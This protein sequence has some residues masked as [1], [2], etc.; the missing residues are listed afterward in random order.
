[1]YAVSTTLSALGP[2]LFVVGFMFL[3]LPVLSNRSTP[4]R[5]AVFATA[6][7]LSWRYA[8]WRLSQTIPDGPLSAGVVMGWGFALLETL[9]IVSSTMSFVILSRRRDRSKETTDNMNWYGAAAPRVDVFIATY[10]E[11]AAL[12]ERTIAGAKAMRYANFKVFVLDDKRRDWLRDLCAQL[13]VGYITRQ[14]NA[15][16]KAGNINNGLKLRAAAAD[17]P[18]FVAVLD[19]DFIPHVGFLSRA[20]ALFADQK[21]GLTQTPQ[22]FF[23]ADP[24]Q[25]N[26]AIAAGYPDEQRYFF[27]EAQASRDAWGMTICCGTSSVMRVAAVEAIGGMP[28]ESVTED[29]L[30]S[31]RLAA[32]GWTTAYLNEPLSEGLAPEGVVEYVVQRGRWCLGVME[33]LRNV[34]NPLK[35]ND[36]TFA[37]RVSLIDTAL[38]WISNF[39]FRIASILMPTCYWL[40]GVTVVDATVAEVLSFYLPYYIFTV[41]ALNWAS[42]ELF[43]PILN[44]VSQ[45]IA[46]PN[47]MRAVKMGLF[48]PGPHKFS[49]TDKGGDRTRSI[50]RWAIAWPFAVLLAIT[51]AALAA[52]TISDFVFNHA[53]KAGDGVV[54]IMLWTV[55]NIVVMI[56]ALLA[57]VD[58]PRS[59]APIRQPSRAATLVFQDARLVSKDEPLV[60]NDEPTETFASGWVVNLS[61][62]RAIVVAPP[63]AEKGARVRLQIDQ[64]LTLEA[65]VEAITA[66]GYRLGFKPDA[67]QKAELVRLLHLHEDAPG[68]LA[69]NVDYMARDLLRTLTR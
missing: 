6:I 14:D 65:T 12:L 52:N 59:S 60:S 36:L 46:A 1:M 38:Y 58:R 9:T 7:A 34:Y 69:G 39:G 56:V 50:M 22:H 41:A 29:Y 24:I 18:A 25:H 63:G 45:L 43:T 15:H 67:A 21:I 49:V 27:D 4:A 61:G 48:E 8:W 37:Y 3:A 11:D 53:G 68:T 13:E 2:A 5:V 64:T 19:A 51:L 66:D 47:V 54:I 57:C 42:R 17:P 20:M 32:H 26:L 23:N 44:D 31:I 30:L 28:T 62:K 40:F 10:N 16:A 35:A 55:Y 33:I